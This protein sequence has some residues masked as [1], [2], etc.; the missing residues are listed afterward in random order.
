MYYGILPPRI[1]PTG[2]FPC[3][4]FVKV[5][6]LS[7]ILGRM[8]TDSHS[9][10]SVN[11]VMCDLKNEGIAQFYRTEGFLTAE[12]VLFRRFGHS[13]NLTAIRNSKLYLIILLIYKNMKYWTR[14]SKYQKFRDVEF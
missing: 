9:T 6:G 3:P 10:A 2:T 13:R 12:H 4:A 11:V 8:T 7:Q 5:V 14:K 1:L